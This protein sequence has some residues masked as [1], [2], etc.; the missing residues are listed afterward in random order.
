MPQITRIIAVRHGETAWNV[1]TRIQGQLDIGL[2]PTGVWQAEQAAIA[3]QSE[4]IDAVVASDLWRAWQTAQIIAAAQNL[5]VT[6]DEALR[7]RGF[8]EFEGQTFAEIEAKFPDQCFKWRK[9]VPDFAPDGG[10]S[11]IAFRTRVVGV[12]THLAEQHLGQTILVVAHGG[13]MDVLYRAAA[14]LELQAPRTWALDNASIN[15]VIWSP[16]GGFF[17]TGWNDTQH[18][19]GKE[20]ALDEGTA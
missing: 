15:R 7:E 12:L 9:R 5:S 13:V 8:G 3:L 4:P 10:E 16:S 14:K 11:L 6:T 17:I 1:A 19:D 20:P 18:L 2:N